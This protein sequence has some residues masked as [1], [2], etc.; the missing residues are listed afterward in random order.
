MSTVSTSVP[1]DVRNE[2]RLYFGE[3]S[4]LLRAFHLPRSALNNM[5]NVFQV[6]EGRTSLVAQAYGYS[7][8][9]L[10]KIWRVAS[11]RAMKNK[12]FSKDKGMDESKEEMASNEDAIF[13]DYL[14]SNFTLSCLRNMYLHLLERNFLGVTR[15]SLEL[16]RYERKVLQNLQDLELVK[17]LK[18]IFGI[19]SSDEEEN[20][21]ELKPSNLSFTNMKNIV[22]T[23]TNMAWTSLYN[24]LSYFIPKW[25]VMNFSKK[26]DP[27]T[28]KSVP[29]SKFESNSKEITP[30]SK[31]TSNMVS[32]S[33]GSLLLCES[34]LLTQVLSDSGTYALESTHNLLKES[35]LLFVPMEILESTVALLKN[36][37]SL[38]STPPLSALWELYNYVSIWGLDIFDE[39]YNQPDVEYAVI[40]DDDFHFIVNVPRMRR[41]ILF[42]GIR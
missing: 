42:I 31:S 13:C 27:T 41:P 6:T 1:V 16:L 22:W 17:A 34:N 11:W 24:R 39:C 10:S 33:A 8:W 4:L 14:A 21:S 19:Q 38:V 26:D 9:I 3:N 36:P 2:K 23:A 20:T 29:S 7:T 35:L 30:N 5:V 32:L 18:R 28:E 40:D 25:A 15:E 12:E 37:A